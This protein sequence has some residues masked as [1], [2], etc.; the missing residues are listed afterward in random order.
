M[1]KVENVKKNPRDGT[2]WSDEN[3]S[4]ALAKAVRNVFYDDP[5]FRQPDG[6]QE[7]APCA[8]QP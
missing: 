7:P 2:A 5:I 1:D 4:L 8:P 6:E 3:L